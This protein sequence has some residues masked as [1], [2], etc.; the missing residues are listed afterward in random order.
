MKVIL[1]LDD[2]YEIIYQYG[3]DQHLEDLAAIFWDIQDNYSLVDS[4]TRAAFKQIMAMV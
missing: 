3:I 1:L 4:L 2:P